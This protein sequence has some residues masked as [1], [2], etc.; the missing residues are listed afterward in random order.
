MKVSVLA[1]WLCTCALLVAVAFLF[2]SNRQK[3][4]EL[5]NARNSLQQ[6]EQMRQALKQL[7]STSATQ[8][9]ELAELRAQQGDLLASHQA[10]R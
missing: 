4:A 8:S 10:S 3:D 9:N 1:P 2:R 7:E 6:A 5:A